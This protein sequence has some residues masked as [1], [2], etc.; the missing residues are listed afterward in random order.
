MYVCMYCQSKIV[1]W[2]FGWRLIACQ[3]FGHI[4]EIN[5]Y[6]YIYIYIR[7]NNEE[8]GFLKNENQCY[9]SIRATL[10]LY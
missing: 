9:I 10:F 4:I 6:I 7:E 8:I 3:P 1:T 2:L 5:V